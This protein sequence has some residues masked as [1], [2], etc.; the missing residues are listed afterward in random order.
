M[1]YS[2]ITAF[3][4]ILVVTL[5]FAIPFFILKICNKKGYTNG[6]P[7]NRTI[8]HVP[9]VLPTPPMP[10]YE[11][12]VKQ[13]SSDNGPLPAN[14]NEKTENSSYKVSQEKVT[15][16]I[17]EPEI[18]HEENK[19][20]DAA[21]EIPDESTPAPEQKK[22]EPK[23]KKIDMTVSNILF[24]IGTAFIVLS[25]IAFGVASWVKTSHEG[26]VSI[27]AVA[28]ALAF[29]FSWIFKKA[30]KLTGSSISFYILGAGFTSTV[31]V[32]AGYYELMGD[33][34]AFSG[35]GCFMLLAITLALTSAL[36]F[37]GNKIFDKIPLIYTALS[38]AA[39][40]ILF[41]VLQIF[42]TIESA[43][44]VLIVLQTIITAFTLR[45]N[46]AKGKKYELPMKRIGLITSLIYGLTAVSYIISSITEPTVS[47]Y[48]CISAIIGQLVFYGLITGKKILISLESVLSLVLAAMI[49]FSIADT[50][51]QRYFPIV[52]SVFAL[53]IYAI[54]RFIP[55]LK[56]GFAE[57][58]TFIFSVLYSYICVAN[59][60]EGHFIPE[61][62]I[63]VIVSVVIT[64]YVFS[65]NNFI[66]FTAGISAPMFPVLITDTAIRCIKSTYTIENK[67]ALSIICWGILAFILITVAAFLILRR[68]SNFNDGFTQD[69]ILHSNIIISGIILILLADY[70]YFMIL[71]LLLCIYHFAVSNKFKCNYPALLSSA[72][73]IKMAIEFSNRF[74]DNTELT[75][76]IIL[77]AVLTIYVVVSKLIYSEGIFVSNDKKVT[78]DTLFATAW[79]AILPLFG[80][81]R[82]NLFFVLTASSMFI[83]GFIRKNTSYET[84]SVI[85]TISTLLTAFAFVTRPFLVP[86]SPEISNKITIGII[87]LTGFVSQI[88]WKKYKEAA[89]IAANIIYI[90]SFISL[91]FDAIYFDTAANT[92]FVM[93]VMVFALV[94]SI[95]TR[96]K[97][98]FITSSS[99]LFVITIFA[100]RE[101]LTSLNWWIYL[102]I[103]GV[104][105]IALAVTN[106]YC[107]KNNETLKS[108]VAKKFSGWNW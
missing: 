100:T 92:I 94:V 28:A 52:F 69:G 19:T 78:I 67:T 72:A 102:F 31:F 91:L 104:I 46:A 21:A 83:T 45:P 76:N 103:T 108:S 56:N 86:D 54:H 57:G 50:A 16:F 73:L 7:Q 59:A 70:S 40:A 10:T 2:F 74:F 51:S 95:M 87:A 89:N 33:W 82:I 106:E 84:A 9:E 61:L 77:L 34:L 41:T 26:K 71:P 27:I 14:M 101:Y 13:R 1:K 43:S 68:D 65:N 18:S 75:Y 97:T 35:E 6:N 99:S 88:V 98:W 11:E 44:P 85:L 47:S 30:L 5:P 66:N 22:T 23:E 105:L 24:L 39:L 42:D 62:I 55:A 32:T 90:L 96:S 8:P 60:Y 53:I 36:M 3:I 29:G 38:T 25:G 15:A 20:T 107:K 4:I 63:G 17:D 48:I 37:L 49:S 64:S 93:S 12:F 79:L 81:E 58:L 80:S